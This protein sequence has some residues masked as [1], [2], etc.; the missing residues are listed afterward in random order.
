MQISKNKTVLQINSESQN[1]IKNFTKLFN[2]KSPSGGTKFFALPSPQNSKISLSKILFK[3]QSTISNVNISSVTPM[4][5]DDIKTAFENDLKTKKIKSYIGFSNNILKY[6]DN[7]KLLKNTINKLRYTDFVKNLSK[8]KG[9]NPL[10]G[11]LNNIKINEVNEKEEN[12]KKDGGKSKLLSVDYTERKQKSE[13]NK[14]I[15]V[16]KITSSGPKSELPNLNT[17]RLPSYKTRKQHLILNKVSQFENN[18]I[19]DMDPRLMSRPFSSVKINNAT[20]STQD[21]GQIIQNM[22]KKDKKKG[23]PK[24]YRSTYSKA[25]SRNKSKKPSK[26]QRPQIEPNKIFLTTVNSNDNNNSEKNDVKNSTETK[27]ISIKKKRLITHF[28]NGLDNIID[29]IKELKMT[30]N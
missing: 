12:E 3:K 9:V 16:N 11:L 14:S 30:I 7:K 21:L 24:L 2:P 19:P 6:Y 8:N 23:V 27:N 18:Y 17:S 15:K 28:D 1:Q 29:F 13:V 4:R 25:K 22:F 5:A 26:K 20:N 10:L